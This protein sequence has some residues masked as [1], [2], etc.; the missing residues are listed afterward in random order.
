MRK[1]E[2]IFMY[3]QIFALKKKGFNI[4]QIA[5]ETG[6]S[7]PTVYKYL[8]M[9][10]EELESWCNDLSVRRKKLDPYRANISEWL[11][12]YP[13]MSSSQVYDWLLEG[14]EALDVAESTV[15]L[16]VRELRETEGITKNPKPRTYMAVPEL[17]PGKQTQVDWGQSRQ[18]KVGGGQIKLYFISFVLSHSRYKFVHWQ[19]RPFTTDDG[20][21]AHELALAYFGGMTEEFVYDQDAII[22]VNENAGDFILTAGFQAYVETRG[23]RVRLCRKED[24]ESKGKVESVVKFVKRNFAANRLYI[25][26]EDW[27]QRSLN[28]LKR[29]GNHRK[30]HLTKERPQ[31]MFISEKK[32]LLPAHPVTLDEN[33]KLSIT[34]TIRKDNSISYQSNRYT[35]PLGTYNRFG[36]QR[37]TLRLEAGHLLIMDP[38]Q[39]EILAKHPLCQDKGKLIGSELHER[40]PSKSQME[41]KE[42]VF[43]LLGFT[44]QARRFVEEI[45]RNYPRHR[46]D[47]FRLII[48]SLQEYPQSAKAALERCI[49]EDAYS[50]NSFKHFLVYEEAWQ[51]KHEP[52]KLLESQDNPQQVLESAPQRSVD[53]YLAKLGVG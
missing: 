22:S 2:R 28:W 38:L 27:N 20:I 46:Q 42:K 44:D 40:Q 6:L 31:K 8:A 13:H 14:D 35:V 12:L 15:R 52:I 41:L 51:K 30:H 53:S 10:L 33:Y 26:L 47:Q 24:P 23:F 16:Y 39:R 18:K 36:G 49:H 34:R 4:S 7:R 37:L 21:R 3:G 19:D 32:H 9:N 43:Q 11:N 1:E 5:H 17:P 29:T 45:W 25:S 50:A 48:R